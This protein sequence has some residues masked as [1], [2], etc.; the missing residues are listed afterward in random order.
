MDGPLRH[1]NGKII[2]ED[3]RLAPFG[4]AGDSREAEPFRSAGDAVVCLNS[5]RAEARRPP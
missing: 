3:E 4:R 5:L 2:A 1:G